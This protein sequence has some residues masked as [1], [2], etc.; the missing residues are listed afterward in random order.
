MKVFEGSPLRHVVIGAGAGVFGMHRAA[1]TLPT[2]KLVAVSD[3][4]R[5][6]GKQRAEEFACPFYSDY[7]QMLSE[8]KPDI[9]VILTPHPLHAEIAIECLRS[10]SHVLVEKPIAIQIADA[11][12]MIATA[13]EH[14]RLLGVVFQQRF[15]PEIQAAHRLL[16][17]GRLGELQHVEM[18]VIWTRPASYYQQGPWRGTWK[19]EG[20]GV[21]MNQAAHNLDILC[22]LLGLPARV[23]AWTR[24]LLHSIETEDTVQAMMEWSN[25]AIGTF[26]AST[27]EPPQAEYLRIS[28]TKGIL[29]IRPNS[30]SLEAL[31][32][33]L[34]E[35]AMQQ[36]SPY[37]N[38][39][40]HSESVELISGKGDHI[41][42]YQHFHDAILHG[43]K[44]TSE[45]AQGSMEL[46]LANAMI[47]SSKTGSIVELPLDRQKYAALLKKLQSDTTQH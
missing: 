47:Y 34:R 20:G 16:Q 29:E 33:D 43:H 41:T 12:A 31:D 28:G 13:Q 17:E 36:T 5:A 25:G 8:V 40:M 39:P 42:V 22:F 27:A 46:E 10:G 37:A 7:H 19:G 44:F 38:P 26:H 14:K 30:L 1:L 32:T 24:R 2:A 45:G 15:R 9:S 21:V 18:A 11:D 35:Y 4:N 6:L 3:I 23:Y